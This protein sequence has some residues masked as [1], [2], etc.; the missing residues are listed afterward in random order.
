[1]LL[2]EEEATG[3]YGVVYKATNIINNKC[4]VGITTV[5]FS[6]RKQVFVNRIMKK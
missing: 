4:Y 2:N 1:M 3:A 6:N 5:G